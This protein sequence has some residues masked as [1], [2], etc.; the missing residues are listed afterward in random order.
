MSDVTLSQRARRAIALVLG[1]INAP[2]PAVM[3]EATLL[4]C[5]DADRPD[6]SWRP[7]IEALF[8]E[9]SIEALHDLVLAGVVD[10]DQLD[11]AAD[12]WGV[13][14]GRNHPWIEEMAA[15]TLACLARGRPPS[16][17]V[18]PGQTALELRRRHG[19]RR[20]V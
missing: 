18:A 8:D 2:R 9:V 11:R 1:T 13:T 12:I 10:F 15:L 20:P 5:L 4:D 3:D 19:A 17:T 16:A 14:D 7:H 6:P